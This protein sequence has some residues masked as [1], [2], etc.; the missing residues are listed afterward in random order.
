MPPPGRGGPIGRLSSAA[1]T[2]G[3][4][5]TALDAWVNDYCTGGGAS[6][7][8]EWCVEFDSR[9]PTTG[10]A[11]APVGFADA[12]AAFARVTERTARYLEGIDHASLAAPATTGPGSHLEGQRVAHLLYRG[13]AHLFAHAGE[14]S[15]VSSLLRRADLG[16]P[17]PLPQSLHAPIDGGE[18]DGSRPLLVR[19]VLDAR[20]AFSRVAHAVPVPA[21][22]G[23][24]D[25]VNAGGWIVAHIAEQEDQYWSVHAQHREPDAWLAAAQV[26]Y[27]DPASR[28]SYVEALGALARATERGTPYLEGLRAEQFGEVLRVSRPGRGVQ[29]AQDLL[30]LQGTHLYALAGELAAIA[31][32]AGASDPELPEPM[33]HTVGLAGT[34]RPIEE[35]A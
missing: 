9:P 13:V 29:T 8:D 30:V 32:L 11:S 28:P 2:V 15:V 7:R 25:R 23:A 33:R 4:A 27:G 6:A 3:H 5:A 19:F 20:E 1:R 14:L 21:Q 16:L 12:E 31:S 26:R 17:G 24:F 22:T 34:T 35:H 18:S 10:P